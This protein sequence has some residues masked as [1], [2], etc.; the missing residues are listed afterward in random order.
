MQLYLTGA[1]DDGDLQSLAPLPGVSGFRGIGELSIRWKPALD[2]EWQTAA[3]IAFDDYAR[4]QFDLVELRSGHWPDARPIAV[5]FNHV[6]PFGVP[7]TGGTVYFE[8]NQRPR[9]V[10]LA[11]TVRDPY[12]F[13]PPFT[14]LPTFCATR[15]MLAELGG[16]YN[17]S[18]IAVA[19]PTYTKDTAEAT[20]EVLEERLERLCL[21]VGFAQVQDPSR[22]FLQDM[23]EGV[24]STRWSVTA[25]SA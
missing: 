13:P 25:R 2:A 10:T 8:V 15:E 3:I 20:V 23:M 16:S 18:R 14:G 19:I 9:P 1:V 21:G 4:Q 5:E 12:Q 6:T 17:Y 7:V 11:G 22:H 24:A